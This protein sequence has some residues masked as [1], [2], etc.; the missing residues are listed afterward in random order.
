MQRVAIDPVADGGVFDRGSVEHPSHG[1]VA[2]LNHQQIDQR[3][4]SS[5]ARLSTSDDA[6]D[7]QKRGISETRVPRRL[8]H[9]S[10]GR[11]AEWDTGTEADVRQGYRDFSGNFTDSAAHMLPSL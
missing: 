3:T 8:S 5:L 11:A 7:G 10:R 6:G 2:L 4:A 9:T 1:V